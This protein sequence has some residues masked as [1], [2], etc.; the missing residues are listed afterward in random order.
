[1]FEPV[2]FMCLGLGMFVAEESNFTSGPILW[3]VRCM[4]P[5]LFDRFNAGRFCAR[6]VSAG[7]MCGVVVLMVVPVVLVVWVRW[8]C[9]SA[10]VCVMHVTC[11]GMRAWTRLWRL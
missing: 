4:Q 2:A 10:R 9:V 7:W 11:A 1:M 8:R 3:L 6:E 5:I